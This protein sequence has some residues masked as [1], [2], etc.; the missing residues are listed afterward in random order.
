MI[1]QAE[2]PPTLPRKRRRSRRRKVAEAVGLAVGVPALLF[3]VLALS[4]E[5]I[6]YRPVSTRAPDTSNVIPTMRVEI[7]QIRLEPLRLHIAEP[8]LISLD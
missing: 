7:P 4:V 5:L 6:E 8:D 1:D 3:V 2:S